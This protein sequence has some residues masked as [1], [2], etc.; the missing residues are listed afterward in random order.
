[1]GRILG[2]AVRRGQVLPGSFCEGRVAARDKHVGA[3]FDHMTTHM[4]GHTCNEFRAVC[5]RTRRQH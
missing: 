3:Q 5:P 1:M 2:E 4:G